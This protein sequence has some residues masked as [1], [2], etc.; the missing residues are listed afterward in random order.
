M[1]A[2]V[3]K[4]VQGCFICGEEVPHGI[5]SHHVVPQ[6]YGG[7]DEEQNLVDLCASCHSAIHKMYGQRFYRELGVTKPDTSESVCSVSDCTSTTGKFLPAT[8]EGVVEGGEVALCD[9]HAKCNESG[10]SRD[11]KHV[12]VPWSSESTP[13]VVCSTHSV[14]SHSGCGSNETYIMKMSFSS[15]KRCLE[16]ADELDERLGGGSW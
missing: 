13:R 11:A 5:H 4:D 15:T 14:C 16:H 7:S 10:C 8:V 9:H 3:G 2:M 1:A 12:V 6:E